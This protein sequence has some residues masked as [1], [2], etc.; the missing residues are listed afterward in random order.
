MEAAVEAAVEVEV[1]V[2]RVR[3]RVRV[4][5]G[6][7][8]GVAV[9]VRGQHSLAQG[10]VRCTFSAAADFACSRLSSCFSASRSS[11]SSPSFA[12]KGKGQRA[13]GVWRVACSVWR[14]ACGVWGVGWG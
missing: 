13:C 11:S 8:V 5:V 1:E 2:V 6:V 7:G 12:C 9:Q 4:R 10:G 14:V 3:V